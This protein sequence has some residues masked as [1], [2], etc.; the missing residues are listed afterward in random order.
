[1]SGSPRTVVLMSLVAALKRVIVAL[2]GRGRVNCL[3][4]PFHDHLARRRTTRLLRALPN[5]GLLVNVGC[6]YRPLEGWINL[7]RA[8]GPHVDVVWDIRRS[9][10]FPTESCSAIISEHLIE[11]LPK[12][13]AEEFLRECLRA[14]E[15]GGVLRLSTPDAE[16]FLRSYASDRAFL[17]APYFEAPIDAPIDRIN[18][19]MR[20]YGQHQ[21]SYD[22]ELLE[23]MLLRVGFSHA[24]SMPFGQS[25]HALLQGIDTPARRFESLYVEARK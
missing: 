10:P 23:L 20:E 16:R 3:T 6:G 21:W 18:I 2:L 13:T 25:P 5:R 7:D 11:H 24:A 4:G 1:L 8:R 15:P 17:Y 19:M 9:L 22:A 12:S 14:L